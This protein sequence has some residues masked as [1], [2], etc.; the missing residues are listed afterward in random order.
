MSN[1]TLM[2]INHDFA[3]RIEEDPA[4]FVELL[5]DVLRGRDH[6]AMEELRFRFGL[7]VGQTRHHSTPLKPDVLAA[8][9]GIEP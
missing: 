1:R 3:H 6:E 2:E 7:T 5:G 4:K 9:G 8:F